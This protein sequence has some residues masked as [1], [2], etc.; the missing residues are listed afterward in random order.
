MQGRSGV[1]EAWYVLD[2]DVAF[3]VTDGEQRRAGAGD[4]VLRPVAA[5]SAV[6]NC[7][8]DA[9]A[10]LLLIAV[11]PPAVTDRLPR[12]RPA[13]AQDAEGSSDGGTR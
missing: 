5:P 6:R 2:G 8:D 3:D 9:P 12:R 4:L 7:S 1:E 10:R 13:V 11:L